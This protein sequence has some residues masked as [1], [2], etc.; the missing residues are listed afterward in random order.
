MPCFKAN[1][2]YIFKDHTLWK[3]PERHDILLLNLI[4]KPHSYH[5]TVKQSTINLQGSWVPRETLV[6]LC[7]TAVMEYYKKQVNSSPCALQHWA[8]SFCVKSFNDDCN[9]LV[10]YDFEKQS[11]G[12]S[13]LY[14]NWHVCKVILQE[15]KS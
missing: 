12:I 15:T 6:S 5:I 1:L 10:W 8:S 13:I 3:N 2:A 7:S 14:L 11:C 4:G 9:V